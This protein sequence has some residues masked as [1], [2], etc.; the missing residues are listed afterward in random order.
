MEH[1]KAGKSNKTHRC[2]G[3]ATLHE[4]SIGDIWKHCERMYSHQNSKPMPSRANTADLE[5]SCSM[6]VS[7]NL[8]YPG[9]TSVL[10]VTTDSIDDGSGESIRLA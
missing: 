7:P 9:R 10:N 6:A 1:V 4:S 8:L 3:I 2:S 5:P